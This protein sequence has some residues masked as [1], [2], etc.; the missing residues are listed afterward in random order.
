MH[1]GAGVGVGDED[2]QAALAQVVDQENGC[3]M[4]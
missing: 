4:V 3:S 1:V 2:V